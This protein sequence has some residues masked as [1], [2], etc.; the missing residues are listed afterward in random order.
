MDYAELSKL[1]ENIRRAI[2][3]IHKLARENQKLV[4]ENRNLIGQVQQMELMI[5]ELKNRSVIEDNSSQQL[6]HYKEKERK[7]RQKIQQMLEKLETIR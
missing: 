7:I 2:G 5:N 6:S 3:I 4:Q 1:E